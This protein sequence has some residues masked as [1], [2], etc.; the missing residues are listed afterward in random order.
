LPQT[1]AA[2]SVVIPVYKA[3]TCLDELAE[4]TTA[5]LAE[6]TEDYE[7]ILV[8]DHGGDR[9]WE[10]IAEVAKKNPRIKGIKLCRNFGQQF[11]L[12]AGIDF[13][14]GDWVVIMDCDLQDRPEVIS[15]LYKKALEGYD[16]V[17]ARRIARNSSFLDRF[18]SKWFYRVF[19][20]LV[21]ARTDHSVGAFRIISRKVVQTFREMP[22]RHR[23]MGGMIQWMGHRTTFIDV[24]HDPRHS[25]RSTY[26]LMGRFNLGFDA[27]ISFSNKPLILSVR[28]GFIIVILTL[29]AAAV[30]T[31]RKL[32]LDVTVEGYTSII[33]SLFFLGGIIIMNIGIVGIYVG[34][35]YD[36]VKK[37]PLYIIEETTFSE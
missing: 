8:E 24:P 14:E 23:F 29:V 11:A 31:Y 9:S 2:L 28:L 12:S 15:E 37:R 18:T 30:F 21:G 19:D 5:A 3:E 22:E 6:I 10:L 16:V 13:A 27:I 7:M 17:L 4:R 32:V 36:Q 33:V 25:G 1:K 35:I 34:R 20:Y 26:T